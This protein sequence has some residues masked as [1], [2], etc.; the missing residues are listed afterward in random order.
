MGS[1][2]AFKCPVNSFIKNT[3]TAY[4]PAIKGD[5]SSQLNNTTMPQVIPGLPCHAWK[6]ELYGLTPISKWIYQQR[7][8]QSYMVQDAQR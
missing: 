7:R 2:A 8:H 3:F 6:R 5:F 4:P 1:V